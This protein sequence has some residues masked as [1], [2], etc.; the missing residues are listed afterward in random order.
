[1]RCGYRR[2]LLRREGWHV[3]VKCV[4]QLYRLEGLQM[5]LN[6]HAEVP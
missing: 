2:M 5:R 1:M 4:H 3:K 6:R